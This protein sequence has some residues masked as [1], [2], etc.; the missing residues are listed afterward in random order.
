MSPDVAFIH[1]VT[2]RFSDTDGMGHVN[3]SRVLSYV[4]DARLAFFN[5][6]MPGVMERGL[7]VAHVEADYLRPIEFDRQLRPLDVSVAVGDVGNSSFTI[8]NEVRQYAEP[9]ARARV[10]LVSFDISTGRSAPL[11]DEQRT[12]LSSS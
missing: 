3:N 11:T 5:T 9:A 10:V 12:A 6:Q 8:K 2:V 4:E 7:V 1:Q